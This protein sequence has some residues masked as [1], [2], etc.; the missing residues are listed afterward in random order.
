MRLLFAGSVFAVSWL[1]W[2]GIYTPLL[3]GLGLLSCVLVLLLARRSGFFDSGV[4][5]L[6]L[7]TRLPAYWFWLFGQIISANLTVA[8]IVLA[9]RMPISPTL[10]EVQASHLPP[11]GQA[12]LGNAITLTPATVC[13][14]V[15]EG[16]IHVHCLTESSAAEL[17]EGEMVRRAEKLMEN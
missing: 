5:S 7:V 11:V 8:R 10:V 2:S 6:H 16:L 15:N 13:F 3:N 9:R 14:D 12:I 4:Y 1:L 17:R